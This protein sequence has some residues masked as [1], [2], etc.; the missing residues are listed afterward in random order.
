[1]L[2]VSDLVYSALIHAVERLSF[3]KSWR[4]KN[5]MVYGAFRMSTGG[6]MVCKGKSKIPIE[7]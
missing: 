5:A 7:K 1:M 3:D 6:I 2:C 4:K